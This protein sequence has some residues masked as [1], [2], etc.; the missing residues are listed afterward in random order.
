[1]NHSDP[2]HNIFPLILE[3]VAREVGDLI[4]EAIELRDENIAQGNFQ[5][6]FS[7]P[8]KKS[9]LTGFNL[10]DSPE[11]SAYLL[12]T[13]DMAIDFGS[14]LIML[15]EN[16]ISTH[17]KQ[18]KLDGEL[19]DAFSEIL[20][21]IS[22]VL[23]STCQKY[24]SEKKLHFIK[25]N[26]EFLPPGTDFF[27]LPQGKI[28]LLSGVFR[29]NEKETGSFYFIFPHSILETKESET[30][31]R[32][33]KE[34]ETITDSPK[35]LPI[36]TDKTKTRDKF[37]NSASEHIDSD[38]S[39]VSDHLSVVENAT[40]QKVIEKFLFESLFSAQDEL[41]ALL[42]ASLE[43]IEQETRYLIKK[44]LLAKIKGKQVLTKF[45][46]SG[47]KEGEGYILFP[48]KDAIFFGAILVMMPPDSITEAIKNGNFDGEVADAFGEI[49]NILVG[50][51]SNQFKTNFPL[52][53]YL[54][55][56]AVETLVPAQV[57]LTS[58]VPF[59][60]EAYYLLSTQIR[61]EDRVYG[62]LEIL[63]SSEALGLP[64]L[65]EPKES[66]RENRITKQEPD[67]PKSQ[68]SS[69]GQKSNPVFNTDGHK[70]QISIISVISHDKSQFK[71]LQES[72][73]Q[74]NVEV[75]LLSPESDLKQQL[76]NKNP[77]CVFLFVKKVNDLGFAQTIKARTALKKKCPLIVAGPEWTRTKV[78]KALKYGA[79][80]ILI[81]PAQ[82][83]SIIKKIPKTL[84]RQSVID[85]EH[86]PDTHS[87]GKD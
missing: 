11:D 52:K 8:R 1:M 34:N 26:L 64:N 41:G 25:G 37:E 39:R 60:A 83:E 71:I 84:I 13:L 43:F 57:D 18:E 44:D 35:Q 49:T 19:L 14:R 80:D 45:R 51:W 32:N 21:I 74:E 73:T 46:I 50:S 48:L 82:K 77:C 62:P 61:M 68:Q 81:T 12:V 9:V 27:P 22:G 63:F 75:M 6:I 7:P 23:N 33:L 72:L 66:T 69:S 78:L 40:D 70:D 42:G 3:Q 76:T 86:D 67:K 4:G 15:P 53:L 29:S 17:K 24:I 30:K 58:T 85:S 28:S 36:K 59:E 5:D 2:F 47:D 54:K 10:K 65:I 38:Q 16:E 20:N 79:T 56:E 87:R 55:K 31:L